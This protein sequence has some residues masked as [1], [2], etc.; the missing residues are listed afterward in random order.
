MARADPED[1]FTYK[2]RSEQRLEWLKT[3]KRPLTDEE[4]DELYRVLHAIYVR[5][6][7]LYYAGQVERESTTKARG[8]DRRRNAQLLEKMLDEAAMEQLP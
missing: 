4:S 5:D 1:V 6:R 7:R 2:T 8:E 3:R